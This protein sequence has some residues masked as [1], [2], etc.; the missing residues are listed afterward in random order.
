M[1]GYE[2]DPV[3]VSQRV[4][5]EL[6]AID[7]DDEFYIGFSHFLDETYGRPVKGRIL[8]NMP[9]SQSL[10]IYHTNTSSID[11]QQTEGWR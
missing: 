8:L 10:Y 5:V 4:F 3:T 6:R 7:P 1:A 11:I 9:H 2:I